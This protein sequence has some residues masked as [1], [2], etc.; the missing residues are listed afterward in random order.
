MGAFSTSR[1]GGLRH[2]SVGAEARS[3]KLLSELLISCDSSVDGQLILWN[4]MFAL[5]D[6]LNDSEHQ[7]A[8]LASWPISTT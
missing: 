8:Y 3:V 7:M 6:Y 4:A 5:C 2:M 1:L